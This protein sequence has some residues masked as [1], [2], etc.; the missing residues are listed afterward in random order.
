[1]CCAG[2]TATWLTQTRP[3]SWRTANTWRARGA[4]NFYSLYRCHDYHFK[5][6]G[7]M[8]LGDPEAAISA[9][10]EMVATLPEE[11]LRVPSPPIADWLEG[12]LP[13]KMHVLIRFGRWDDIIATE[14]RRTQNSIASQQQ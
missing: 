1:M 4:V 8:F 6:Y 11:L 5:I 3:P 10:D 2:N 7:A 9:A 12:F 14:L 13:M